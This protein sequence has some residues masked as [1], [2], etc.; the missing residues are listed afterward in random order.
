MSKRI[1]KVRTVLVVYFILSL[2][3]VSPVQAKELD[4]THPAPPDRQELLEEITQDVPLDRDVEESDTESLD[5]VSSQTTTPIQTETSQSSDETELDQDPATNPQP[6]PLPSAQPLAPVASHSTALSETDLSFNP[7][8]TAAPQASSAATAI[9]VTNQTTAQQTTHQVASSGSNST[10]ATE[11]TTLTTATTAAQA[12]L[13]TELN[14]TII[15]QDTAYGVTHL[16]QPQDTLDLSHVQKS[17]NPVPTSAADSIAISNQ[18]VIDNMITATAD[19][20]HNSAAGLTASV[21]TGDALAEANVANIANTSLIGNCWF[22]QVITL[23]SPS[24]TSIVLPN[25]QQFIASG[26]SLTLPTP[27]VLESTQIATVSTQ[28]ESTTTT[29]S[30]TAQHISTGDTLSLTESTTISNTN[31]YG[32]SWFL[33]KITNPQYWKGSLPGGNYLSTSDHSALYFWLPPNLTAS[34]DNHLADKIS[35]SNT[36]AINTTAAL[37][38]NSGNNTATGADSTITTGKAQTE[39]EVLNLINTTI[40]GNNWYFV[41]LNLFD[42]FEGEVSIARPDLSLITPTKATVSPGDTITY[43]IAVSN[44]GNAA[45]KDVVITQ[46]RAGW[47]S[48]DGGSSKTW[49]VAALAEQESAVIPVTLRIPTDA[50]EG[51]YHVS[52]Q[53]SNS[54][55]EQTEEN[56]ISSLSITVQTPEPQAVTEYFY[57]QT[58][59]YTYPAFSGPTY[60]SNVQRD[61]WQPSTTAQVSG[62]QDNQPELS[63]PF[64]SPL[65]GAFCVKHWD[66]CSA[67][68]LLLTA[69]PLKALEKRKHPR[70]DTLQL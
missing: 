15:G 1:I 16:T 41:L 12:V 10:Q 27:P 11:A 58:E 65:A 38:A 61:E 30:N 3:F 70:K 69:G 20:G 42:T 6:T 28:L 44:S 2:V 55:T 59:L 9:D 22:Y 8:A 51:T 54:Y 14:T 37:L 24:A 33:I 26:T 17:C 53:V 32:S 13:T 52:Y 62:D 4:V 18:A 60:S 46:K 5:E 48:S 31:L 43:N 47:R 35:I 23:F 39:L 66:I 19:S 21:S 63:M 64:P 29:G 56:N 36:A 67:A 7:T 45:A 68:G 40:V 50:E 49:S 34:S 25:E 57:P